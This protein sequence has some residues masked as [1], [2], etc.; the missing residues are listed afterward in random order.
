MFTVKKNALIFSSIFLIFF[1]NIGNC[2]LTDLL[3]N[4]L[5][6]MPQLTGLFYYIL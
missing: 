4:G 3:L 6:L 1:F 5:K 2:Y